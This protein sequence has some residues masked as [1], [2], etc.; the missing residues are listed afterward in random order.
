MVL[1]LQRQKELH[2][3]SP[4][5]HIHV[6]VSDLYIPTIGLPVLLQENRGTDPLEYINR[7]QTHECG[8][9]T[10]EALFLFWEYRNGIFVAVHC[11]ISSL[12]RPPP[13]KHIIYT[14]IY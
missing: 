7:S 12:K 10:E 1:T 4:N 3:L 13:A 6:Y 8:I 5:V 9:G 2:G 11:I 14:Y